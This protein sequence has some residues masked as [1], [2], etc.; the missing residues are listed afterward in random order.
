LGQRRDIE[1]HE[2]IMA[3]LTHKMTWRPRE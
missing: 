3:Q 2:C 1:V